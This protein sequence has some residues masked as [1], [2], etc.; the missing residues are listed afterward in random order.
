MH[1]R[2]EAWIAGIV[3]AHGGIKMKKDWMWYV[4]E[5]GSSQCRCGRA[6]G[7]RKSFCPQC[8]GRLPER[9]K[10]RLYARCGGGYEEAYDEARYHLANI[11]IEEKK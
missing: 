7:R 1:R 3:P 8:Y 4:L 6:K 5:L 9:L 2:E 10:M 11:G